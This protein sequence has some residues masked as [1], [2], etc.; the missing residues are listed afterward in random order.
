MKIKKKKKNV[1]V[2]YYWLAVH[3][4][5]VSID[6]NLSKTDRLFATHSES[7]N[8]FHYVLFII[9]KKNASLKVFINTWY[10]VTKV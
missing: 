4:A 7:D 8:K 9:K 5:F 6:S 3:S 10:L 1:R 2:K